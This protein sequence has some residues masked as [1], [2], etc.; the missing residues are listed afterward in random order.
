MAGGVGVLADDLSLIVD[1][2]RLRAVV[3][4]E[5]IVER[6]VK[7]ALDEKA[8]AVIGT[9]IVFADDRERVIDTPDPGSPVQRARARV[10]IVVGEVTAVA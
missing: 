2:T 10:R 6:E 3:P 8:V 9:I 1:A 4:R 7:E 5:R